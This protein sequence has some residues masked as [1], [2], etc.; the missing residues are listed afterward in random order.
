MAPQSLTGYYQRNDAPPLAAELEKIQRRMFP[1]SQRLVQ[2]DSQ[3]VL[4]LLALLNAERA[5][6]LKPDYVAQITTEQRWSIIH[7]LIM[8]HPFQFYDQ[9]SP[10]TMRRYLLLLAEALR[11]FANRVDGRIIVMHA[12]VR[13][14]WYGGVNML[15]YRYT[16]GRMAR[17][18]EFQIEVWDSK[19]LFKHIQYL[20]LSIPDSHTGGRRFVELGGWIA[21]GA[22]QGYGGQYVDALDSLKAAVSRK[23]KREPWHDQ[24]LES[25]ENFFATSYGTDE[26][27]VASAERE[28]VITFRN[29]IE[30]VLLEH[31]TIRLNIKQGFKF[32]GAKVGQSLQSAGPSEDNAH[33]YEYGLLDLLY[34]WSFKIRN[35]QVCFTEMIGA[36]RRVLEGSSCQRLHRKAID[37]YRHLT[38][39]GIPHGVIYGDP[40][41]RDAID[42]WINQ[43]Q[44][45]SSKDNSKR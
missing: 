21:K 5:M 4:S 41:E 1:D 22:L 18:P 8:R 2:C 40:E 14:Q 24:Y 33:Y 37:L 32:L 42:R 36:V 20:L 30:R 23:H 9:N 6:S 12:D 27:G 29:E 35:H 10:I 15:Y 7:D 3:H 45:G 43:F 13:R 34:R 31:G 28:V 38:E 39:L 25:E 11:G 26:D 44:D 17:S 19:F 16:E